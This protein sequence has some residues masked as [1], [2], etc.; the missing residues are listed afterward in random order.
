MTAELV[1]IT[2]ALGRGVSVVGNATPKPL[3]DAIGYTLADIWQGI[4]GD[5]VA[6]WR[7]KNVAAVN[8]R[9]I[10]KVATTGQRIDNSRI[11]ER[12]AFSWF[13]EASKQ[14]ES[15]IQELFATLLSNAAAGNKDALQRRNVR[16]VSNMSP[17]EAELFSNIIN[18]IQK[19]PTLFG[20]QFFYFER[21]ESFFFNK[22]DIEESQSIQL[23]LESLQSNGILF[24]QLHINSKDLNDH[25][26]MIGSYIGTVGPEEGMRGIGEDLVNPEYTLSLTQTGIS[27]ARALSPT[28]FF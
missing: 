9:L 25:L 17:K 23:S 18:H 16:L 22:D 7:L 14:D 27:L 3:T 11:S 8:E 15:E 26:E 12:Y 10:A 6:A 5:K 2:E 19:Q 4:I 20:E 1:P 24:R 28:T 21:Y 13:E